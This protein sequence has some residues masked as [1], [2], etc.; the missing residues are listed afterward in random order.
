MIQG[1]Q[2]TV[3]CYCWHIAHRWSLVDLEGMLESKPL[4]TPLTAFKLPSWIMVSFHFLNWTRRKLFSF[5]LPLDKQKIFISL[6]ALMRQSLKSVPNTGVPSDFTRIPRQDFPWRYIIISWKR[7]ALYS[8]TVSKEISHTYEV[9]M[10]FFFQS[11]K[12]NHKASLWWKDWKE[13]PVKNSWGHWVCLV[14]T[15]GG[16]GMISLLLKLPEEGKW[17]ERYCGLPGTQGKDTWERFST[18]PGEVYTGH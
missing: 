1:V 13:C 16:W 12:K 9:N 7:V 6:S 4:I 11:T 14:W 3:T 8:F 15:K 5:A 10:G 18:L 17:R 2:P